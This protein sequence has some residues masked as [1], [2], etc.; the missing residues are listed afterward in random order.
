MIL[1][2]FGNC[3]SPEHYT[4]FVLWNKQDTQYSEYDISEEDGAFVGI[5]IYI[6][7]LIKNNQYFNNLKRRAV[8]IWY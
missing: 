3:V 7:K 8:D 5:V 6:S 2:C 1:F 4:M